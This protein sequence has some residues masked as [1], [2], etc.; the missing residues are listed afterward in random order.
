MLISSWSVTFFSNLPLTGRSTTKFL[1]WGKSLMWDLSNSF[2]LP[3]I[4]MTLNN[5]WSTLLQRERE[6]GIY[7]ST[8][9]TGTLA[10][11]KS[12]LAVLRCV[13]VLARLI[14]WNSVAV[15]LLACFHLNTCEPCHQTRTPGNGWSASNSTKPSVQSDLFLCECQTNQDSLSMKNDGCT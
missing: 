12:L 14:Q 2:E 7:K 11:E 10:R 9:Q 13:H 3:W 15:V 6:H 5:P 1:F 4:K 8:R